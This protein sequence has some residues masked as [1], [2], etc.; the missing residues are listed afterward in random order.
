M[1]RDRI[2]ALVQPAGQKLALYTG[3]VT[4]GLHMTPAFLICG[5]Q[6]GGTTSM[7]Q[8]L[9]Q[10]PNVLRPFLHKGVHYFDVKPERSLNWYRAHFPF[11]A[12]GALR[13]RRTGHPAMTFESSPYYLFHPLAAGRIANALP[14]VKV[15]ILL[16]DPV[17]RAYSAHAHELA[18]GFETEPFERAVELEDERVAG[19]GEKLIADPTYISHAHQHQAYLRRGC[20]LP[21]IERM[22]GAIGR[23]RVHLVDSED[24]FTDPEPVWNEVIEFLDLPPQH[25]R[26]FRRH[27]ARPRSPMPADLRA[28]LTERFTE[29]DER[30]AQWWGRTPSWRR[31]AP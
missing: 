8:A 12:Q 17:E 2:E 25:G 11:T 21:Q 30:L 26:Q 24:F 1:N 29:S 9:R 20:Y 5:A 14:G 4:P 7:Y 15:L 31:P 28:R 22:T 3:I 16:R 27:N 18:R 6:R 10:H 23:D 13:S 19:E